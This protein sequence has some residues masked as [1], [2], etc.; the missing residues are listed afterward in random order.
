M[1]I[2]VLMHEDLIPP[3]EKSSKSLLE[4]ASWKTEYD[5]MT[6]LKKMGHE[7]KA[8]G[9]GYELGV[10]RTHLY[11]FEPHLIFNLLEEFR[12][13][14]LFDYYIVAYL[15][16][17][18]AKYTGCNPRGLLLA[19][20]KALGKKILRYHRIATPDFFV[21][22]KGKRF[23]LKR[24]LRYPLFVKTLNEEASL[25][26]AQTSVVTNEKALR[27]RIEYIFEKYQTDVLVENYIEG[28]EFYV[29]LIGNTRVEVLPLV[30]LDFGNVSDK[31]YP[32]ATRKVKW[33]IEYRE[34]NRI[35]VQSPKDLPS[36]VEQK[37]K[38]LSQRA[39][40]CLDMS[41][42]GRLDL[43]M[44]PDGEV[45]VIEANPNPDIGY[46]DEF[47]KSAELAGLTYE[48]LLQKIVQLGSGRKQL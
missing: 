40:R 46:G 27:E 23:H 13:Q 45:Y 8:L 15:E 44:S 11:E 31:G 33:D 30:E 28:R 42:Y 35:I 36:S 18:S 48:K 17:M 24:N 38:H 9:V 22:Q 34:Q 4:S 20:D 3:E 26:I 7:V 16:L 21:F 14:A 25:G 41:G 5:V 43:R 12:G 2:T 37:I 32:I 10:I 6:H 1:R 19:R 29:S 39:Y 47:H